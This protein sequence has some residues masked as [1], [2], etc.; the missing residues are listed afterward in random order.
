MIE[1]HKHSA[2]AY[3]ILANYKIGYIDYETDDE[4]EDET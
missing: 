4:E 2:K 3:E 1:V